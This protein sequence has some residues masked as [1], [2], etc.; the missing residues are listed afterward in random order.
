M[1]AQFIVKFYQAASAIATHAAFIA[2]SVIINHLKIVP[3][4][5]IQKDETIRANPES[6]V[7]QMSYLPVR[8][9]YIILPV[10]QNDKIVSC[11]MVFVKSKFHIYIPSIIS[12]AF[13]IRFSLAAV[14]SFVNV[15]LR[16]FAT[17]T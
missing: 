15:L 14:L 5:C 10:V 9:Y 13:I 4:F 8:H 7:T 3:F 1:Y 11:A 17:I 2:I 12:K 6:P 16:R